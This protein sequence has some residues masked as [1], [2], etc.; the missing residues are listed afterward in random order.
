MFFESVQN[1]KYKRG[2]EDI[3]C[4][5]KKEPPETQ[6]SPH[7]KMRIDKK[8]SSKDMANTKRWQKQNTKKMGKQI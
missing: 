3:K 6:N 7:E 5:N 8:K 4:H 1:I 2:N